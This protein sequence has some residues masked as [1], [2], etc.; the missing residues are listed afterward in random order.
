MCV[1]WRMFVS[2][3][4]IKLSYKYTV[5]FFLSQEDTHL[6]CQR[7]AQISDFKLTFKFDWSS[8]IR[9]LLSLSFAF[10]SPP[11]RPLHFTVFL[12]LCLSVFCFLFF[13]REKYVY[14]CFDVLDHHAFTPASLVKSPSRILAFI[15]LRG[16]GLLS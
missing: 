7:E 11:P 4:I 16:G 13:R 10:F 5:F 6:I 8:C 15:C 9:T 3:C 2:M 14:E 1:C 12:S